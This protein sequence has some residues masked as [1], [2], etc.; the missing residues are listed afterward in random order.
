MWSPHSVSPRVF[1]S[2]GQMPGPR[3]FKPDADTPKQARIPC[4]AGR[5]GP[6]LTGQALLDCIRAWGKTWYPRGLGPVLEVFR[7][8]RRG[9]PCSRG[10][11]AAPLQ[12][13]LRG[14]RAIWLFGTKLVGLHSG[15]L[16]RST[17]HDPADMTCLLDIPLQHSHPGVDRML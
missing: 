12:E 7:S 13:P 6:N 11:W 10:C 3:R 4:L 8:P 5:A 15:T 2:R 16:L 1:Q 17:T 14:Y 9:L